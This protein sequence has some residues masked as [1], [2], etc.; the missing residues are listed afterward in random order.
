MSNDVE[1]LL[2]L[3]TW[4]VVLLAGVLTLFLAANWIRKRLTATQDQADPAGLGFSLADLRKLHKEGHL[5]DE[6]FEKAKAKIV[7]GTLS[8]GAKAQRPLQSEPPRSADR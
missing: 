1:R 7:G 2:P 8:A 5:T 3:L 6:E 4:G